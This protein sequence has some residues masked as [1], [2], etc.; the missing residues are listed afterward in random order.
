MAQ[1]FVDKIVKFWHAL[2]EPPVEAERLSQQ[3]KWTII[4]LL[5]SLACLVR[6]FHYVDLAPLVKTSQQDF[7]GITA[8][9]DNVANGILRDGIQRVFPKEWPVTDTDLLQYPPGYP[10]F[11]STIYRLGS[12]DPGVVQLVQGLL[13]A[14]AVV[15]AFLIALELFSRTIAI[16]AGIAA[17]LSHH[18][19]YYSMLLLPDSIVPVLIMAGTLLLI[20]AYKVSW[21]KDKGYRLWAG[22]GVFY[23]VACWFRS[24]ALLLG[25]FWAVTL[26]I[27]RKP[28]V[29]YWKRA[30]VLVFT[31]LAVIAPITIRNY[32]LFN[33]F[34]PISLGVGVTLQSGLGEED[35]SLELPYKDDKTMAWEAKL[36]NRPDYTIG[37]MKPDGILR[38]HDRTQRSLKI[39]MSRPF[40]YLGVML[41]RI[42]LMMKYSAHADLVHAEIPGATKTLASYETKYGKWQGLASYYREQ[43]SPL[44]YLRLLIR[45]LQRG[46]KEGLIFLMLIGLVLAF[47]QRP[48][49][50]L[51]MTVPAYYLLSHS[52]LHTEFRYALP[53]HYLLFIFYALALYTIFVTLPR[54]IRDGNRVPA[55]TEALVTEPFEQM[56]VSLKHA[57]QVE[58]MSNYEPNMLTLEA[59]EKPPTSLVV[60]RT[61]LPHTI[62]RTYIANIGVD[63]L[64]EMETLKIIEK[65]VNERVPRIMTVVNASKIALAQEDQALKKILQQAD[66]VT[67]D[68]MSVVWASQFLGQPLKE[69][70]TGIDIFEKLVALSARKNFSVYFLGA[71]PEVV[72]AL[73]VHFRKKYPSLKIAGYHN[74]YFGRNED[75]V[76]RI[77]QAAPDILFVA[78]GSPRQEQWQTTYLNTLNVP[79]TI[80]VGGSFDHVAGF[81]RRA[82]K[83]MQN[84]GLEWLYRLL[85]EPQRLWRRYLIGNTK[86]IILV[87]KA[88][89]NK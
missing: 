12:R 61:P 57:K 73:A 77:Q 75:A 84:M 74:G 10:L 17:A 69:R 19:A 85:S 26:F 44:D 55:Y 13:D 82:P 16:L 67:A 14:I 35:E 53:A 4:V 38:E 9:H 65:I 1:T 5:F 7:A 62:S 41:G 60:E 40:W 31:M 30:A 52:L 59:T 20:R 36:Y 46:F 42:N 47:K 76:E 18:L 27:L 66:I 34:I 28:I 15:L 37:L 63:N 23:G 64:S 78:M 70:V 81:S 87:L 25:I 89:F 51:I 3:R 71:K 29:D 50:L 39:I 83:W 56:A 8:I 45:S 32:Y 49:W 54:R 6:Y 43:A 68:G 48:S 11:L 80:G 88:R 72:E 22:A 24:D 21:H 33:E 2:P 79:F 86:F 58:Q